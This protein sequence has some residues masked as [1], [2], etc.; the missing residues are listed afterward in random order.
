MKGSILLAVGLGSALGGL[1]RFY[2]DTFLLS[3]VW[4]NTYTSLFLINVLG[5]FLIGLFLIRSQTMDDDSAKIYWHFWGVGFCGGFTT[6]ASFVFLLL[7]GLSNESALD[8]SI[9]ATFSVLG[10][11]LALVTGLI[12]G[13]KLLAKS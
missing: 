7:E 10:G 13:Q 3:L 2:A 8:T 9:Y 6:F 12:M 11:I 5:S 4:A 1:S